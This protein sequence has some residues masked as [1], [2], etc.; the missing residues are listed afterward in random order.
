MVVFFDIDGTLVDEETQIIPESAVRAVEQLGKNGHLAVI[1]TGRPFSHIDP[2]IREMAFGGWVCG[3][4]MEIVLGDTCISRKLP[5]V[6]VCRLVLKAARECRMQALY[7]AADGAMLTDGEFSAHHPAVVREAARMREKGFVVCDIDQR[8]EPSFMKMGTWDGENCDR[9]AFIAQAEPYF[10][11]IERGDTMLE[12][13]LKGCSKADGMLELL[14]TLGVSREDTVA[15]GDS[16]N[17]LP[18]FRV[19]GHTVCM[20]GG[21]QE[22]KEKAE[23]ITDTVMNDGIEKALRHYGLIG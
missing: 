1:N 4:G 2:R 20:G 22:L 15:I 8:P 3:C 17:D 18:M 19:A 12:L 5:S 9:D 11:C 23:Y 10:T 6:E 13:V 16:I 7:E 21:K 14:E